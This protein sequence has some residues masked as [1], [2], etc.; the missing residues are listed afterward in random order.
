M[1]GGVS[2]ALEQAFAFRWELIGYLGGEI[3]VR[4]LAPLLGL[5]LSVKLLMIAIPMATVAGALWLSREAHG[6][7]Q[8][9]AILALPL[10][11]NFAFQMGF[12]NYTLAMAMMLNAL[13]LWM[14]LGRFGRL[15]TRA[16]LFVPLSFAIWL[17]HFFAWIVLGLVLF[18][19]ELTRERSS[20]RGWILSAWY[21]GIACLPLSLPFL[22]FLHWEPG[23]SSEQDFWNSLL[24]KP[25]WLTSALRDRW[26]A[27]DILSVGLIIAAIYAGLRFSVFRRSPELLAGAGGL[28]LLF[29]IMPFGAAYADARLVPFVLML[30]VLAIGTSA[31]MPA[32]RQQLIVVLVLAFVVVRTAAGTVSLA[33]E[34]RNWD[35]HL[36]SLHHIPR[37]SRVATFVM[38]SCTTPWTMER[39][40]HLPSMAIVR[41]DSFTNDQWSFGGNGTLKIRAQGIEGFDSDPSQMVTPSGCLDSRTLA[42]ALA[43]LPRTHFDYVWI[44]GAEGFQPLAFPWLAPAWV[45]NGDFLLRIDR[46]RLS[47]PPFSN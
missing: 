38:N 25:V 7:V 26:A 8:P 3:A 37:A 39:L 45:D 18:C 22:M 2:P 23:S 31:K 1:L 11:Y 36:E 16:A 30:A 46:R 42:Q 9:L 10:A 17:A 19:A 28:F 40:N 33:L 35:R 29:L 41:R 32:S 43:R 34:N 5:E 27:F 44:I 15:R 12:V 14:R 24:R 13:A 6:R 21:A 20:R 4:V 47:D